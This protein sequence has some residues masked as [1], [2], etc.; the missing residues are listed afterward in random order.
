VFWAGVEGKTFIKENLVMV[1]E[2]ST[3]DPASTS[4]SAGTELTIK[5]AA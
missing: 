3:P 5:N 4:L 1:M 2:M